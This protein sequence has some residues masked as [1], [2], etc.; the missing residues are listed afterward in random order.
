MTLKR[1][2]QKYLKPREE[3]APIPYNKSISS[4]QSI[5]TTIMPE[6]K[7]PFISHSIKA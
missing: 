7:T 3:K 1:I 4:D 6:T 5:N 2:E